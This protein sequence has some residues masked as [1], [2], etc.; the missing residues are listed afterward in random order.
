MTN[1]RG[2]EL[3]DL[4][5]DRARVER[6]IAS[7]DPLLVARA[8]PGGAAL[9]V[10]SLANTIGGWLL[11][12]VSDRGDV[13]GV[14][15]DF[16]LAELLDGEVSPPPP[17]RAATM[18]VAGRTIA[19]VCVAASADTP[20][21][22]ADG[23]VPVRD[24]DGIRPA[25]AAALQALVER[26]RHGEAD[27]SRRRGGLQLI[28][29]AMR[30]PERLPGDAP[31]LD[32]DHHGHDAPLEFIVRATPVTVTADLA[33]RAVS[34]E[35]ASLAARQAIP[36]LVD[37]D[38]VAHRVSTQVDG[39]ARGVYCVAERGEAPIFADLALD[40]GGVV[41]ARLAERRRRDG[42]VT[43]SAVHEEVLLPLLRTVAGTLEGLQAT[44]R[45]L[46]GLEIRGIADLAVEWPPDLVDVV[47]MDEL[48][49]EDRLLLDGDLALPASAEDLEELAARWTRGLARAAGLPAWE[50]AG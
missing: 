38:A 21:M 50:P 43:S 18:D 49:D 16:D 7:G 36:L 39:R 28:E 23:T 3:T 17:A 9:A 34:E 27:A 30:T 11:V 44:G 22:T 37:P 14:P 19:V 42:T 40:A 4:L 13:T 31:I 29:E 25:D 46:L 33:R 24:H 8:E 5:D 1:L 45:A 6:L 48:V 41:A 12:G 26:G 32:P 15:Y 2:L 47:R 35:A 10:A 20:H